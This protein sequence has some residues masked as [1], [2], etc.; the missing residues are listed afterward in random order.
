MSI[1]FF[2]VKARLFKFLGSNKQNKIKL[3]EPIIPKHNNQII[4]LYSKICIFILQGI[5]NLMIMFV[6]NYS[7]LNP[8]ILTLNI[9]NFDDYFIRGIFSQNFLDFFNKFHS[10]NFFPKID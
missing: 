4:L 2:P 3:I 6:G 10:S 8:L 9:L 5:F 7:F 1:D